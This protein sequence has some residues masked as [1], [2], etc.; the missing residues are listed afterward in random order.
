M[1]L[2]FKDYLL[3]MVRAASPEDS[4]DWLKNYLEKAST[5]K[6][7]YLRINSRYWLQ[8]D[9][10]EQLLS[11]ML[12]NKINVF[13]T[14]QD[15]VKKNIRYLMTTMLQKDVGFGSRRNMDY[16]KSLEQDPEIALHPAYGTDVA[17]KRSVG[18]D[19]SH[20]I[21]TT[22]SQETKAKIAAGRK[23][24][25]DRKKGI[26]PPE[27]PTTKLPK[28]TPFYGNNTDVAKAIEDH[29]SNNLQAI[30]NKYLVDK[31]RDANQARIS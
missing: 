15:A 9:H 10:F 4:A 17:Y 13:N 5:G 11:Q 24:W 1:E 30:R 2:N 6:T 19:G 29:K 26:L 14:D 16:A 3:E 8:S 23:A 22:H 18:G 12:L 27:L 20:R 28:R 7:D 31:I 21:G 25:W